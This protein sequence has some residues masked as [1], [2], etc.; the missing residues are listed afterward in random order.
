MNKKIPCSW[1]CKVKSLF[2][3]WKF[4]HWASN[5]LVHWLKFSVIEQWLYFAAPWP[6]NILIHSVIF[7]L[8]C[9]RIHKP[10]TT[11]GMAMM[12]FVCLCLHKIAYNKP[13]MNWVPTCTLQ[14]S[15]HK[16]LKDLHGGCSSHMMKQTLLDILP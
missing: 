6:R 13:S 16:G 3:V 5:I 7:S 11:H 9:N 8:E 4:S 10:K 12:L 1:C 2:N 15:S 14:S